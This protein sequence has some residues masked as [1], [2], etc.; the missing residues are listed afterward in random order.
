MS[1]GLGRG[2]EP[3]PGLGLSAPSR[4]PASI[5]ESEIRG[6]GLHWAPR[7]SLMRMWMRPLPGP[8]MGLETPQCSELLPRPEEE[9]GEGRENG[10]CGGCWGYFSLQD[11]PWTDLDRHTGKPTAA[12]P[13]RSS[14]LQKGPL[15]MSPDSC[16]C[17]RFC[18]EGAA[19][20]TTA[21]QQQ[22][23]L[24]QG[25]LSILSPPPHHPRPSLPSPPHTP[26][27]FSFPPPPS[28]SFP[29]LSFIPPLLTHA[30]P[31]SYSAL[32]LSA[33]NL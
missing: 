2:Q 4:G 8:G 17:F 29:P 13:D 19:A 27:P 21:S 18:E 9:S 12:G 31:S 1:A 25:W 23:P 5:R 14:T 7:R 11:K 22:E 26:L 10:R 24:Y 30:P 6:G 20:G 32:S 3:R 16:R 28:I 33:L 15:L